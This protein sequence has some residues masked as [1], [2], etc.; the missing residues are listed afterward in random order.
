MTAWAHRLP[1]QNSPRLR[2]H[3]PSSFTGKEKD[4]ETGYGYFGARYMDHELMTMWLSVDPMVDKYPSIS[5]YAYCSWNPVKLVDPYGRA[6]RAADKQSRMNI[7]HSLSKAEAKYVRFD[8]NGNIDLRRLGKCKSNSKNFNA[9]KTL[10][11]SKT[12]YIFSVETRHR[13]EY[14]NIDLTDPNGISEGEH[15]K[16][17]T[18]IPENVNDPSPNKNV[19]IITSANM[20]EED[21]V[22]NVAHE[23]YGHAY[24]YELKQQG[25]NVNPN[26]DYQCTIVGYEWDEKMHC[27]VPNFGWYEA[28]SIL[29][30]QI[31]AAVLEAKRNYQSWSE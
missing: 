17:V 13:D 24:L 22:A 10:A 12:D 7:M 2:A 15:V 4:E 19:Y 14:N 31:D 29:K 9:L 26:H 11:Q 1:S 28:N 27:N 6:V 16:G 18:L 30:E 5:P 23:G 3:S 8:K 25:Q 21:Q 20:S